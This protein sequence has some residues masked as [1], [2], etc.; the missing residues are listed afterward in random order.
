[1]RFNT[2]GQNL[3][4]PHKIMTYDIERYLLKYKSNVWFSA[5]DVSKHTGVPIKTIYS[6]IRK[7]SSQGVKILKSGRTKSTKY[8]I[9]S[10]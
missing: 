1:M 7:M 4:G 2:K 9:V 6:A 8:Y 3:R 10:G 5:S